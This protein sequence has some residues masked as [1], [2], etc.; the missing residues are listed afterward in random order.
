MEAIVGNAGRYIGQEGGILV[1]LKDKE[2]TL[3]DATDDDVGQVLEELT[4]CHISI[5][6]VRGRLTPTTVFRSLMRRVRDVEL[7]FTVEQMRLHVYEHEWGWE[8]ECCDLIP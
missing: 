2:G 7:E 4:R 1:I 5:L 8:T 6:S 3:V